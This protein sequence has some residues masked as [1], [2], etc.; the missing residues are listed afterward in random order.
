MTHIETLSP[1]R[2][3]GNDQGQNSSIKAASEVA[4]NFNY[5]EPRSFG[6]N[7]EARRTSA[8]RNRGTNRTTD[9]SQGLR[10]PPNAVWPE[11]QREI[12]RV[13]LYGR[14]STNLQN[15]K[16]V[17]DQFDIGHDYSERQPNW[18]IVASFRDEAISGESL[19]IRPG[20]Q[21]L[22]EFARRRE[23]DVVWAEALDRLS[24]D[25]GDTHSL[26]KQLKFAGVRI[27]TLSEGEVNDLIIGFKGTMNGEF[28]A[29]LRR[30]VRRGQLAQ[31]RR[32]KAVSRPAYGYK[33]VKHVD[34]D[35]DPIR[36]DQK[37]NPTEAEIVNRVCRDYANGVS[38]RKIVQRLNK[39]DIP[40]PD[41][42][43]WTDTV[44]RGH[45]NRGT[46]IINNELYIGKRVWDRSH[47][48]KNPYTGKTVI[49]PNPPDMWQTAEVP[50]LRI[51]SD[52]LWQA[53]KAR[54]AAL[55]DQYANTIAAGRERASRNAA[56][57]STHRPRTPLS[58]LLDC[59]HCGSP[60]V[61]AGGT[62]YGCSRHRLNVTCTNRRTISREELEARVIAALRGPLLDPKL[63]EKAVCSYAEE[64]ERLNRAWR[65]S[66]DS[67]QKAL[68]EVERK[69][70]NI[71]DAIKDGGYT[72]SL[73]TEQHELEAQEEELKRELASA[74]KEILIRP[75]IAEEFRREVEHLAEALQS[76]DE[77]D[78]TFAR[79][80]RLID[81]ITITP[82]LTAKR[83]R[84]AVTLHGSLAT[85]LQMSVSVD[86]E[87]HVH[88]DRQLLA[89]AA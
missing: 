30:K 7:E 53:V 32:G 69:I 80:C 66:Y 64:M 10:Q 2:R 55:R 78:E 74:P 77:F 21:K 86:S 37:I 29:E 68:L 38:P 70:R 41:G 75:D 48:V 52:E 87:I 45:P 19:V 47:T 79:I 83:G 88:R 42:A 17:D 49:R 85:M 73:I 39:E 16:S 12:I 20:I 71:T 34:A 81:H 26:Y 6:G 59:G 60:Y 27:V 9:G 23:F 5:C 51:V 89:I 82:D 43:P 57:N 28:L 8:A 50:E 56:L 31:V 40:G 4:D 3:V 65:S 33:M 25:L 67:R 76:F 58:G 72:R 15:P 61:V 24:R 62:R 36:G 35:G 14:Y 22:I 46:G 18:S 11:P 63:V 54:Q 13:A 84:I 1:T 44:I